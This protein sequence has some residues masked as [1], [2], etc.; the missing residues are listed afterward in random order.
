MGTK[1]LIT[2][3]NLLRRH[4]HTKDGSRNLRDTNVRKTKTKKE[5]IS[6]STEEGK[7]QI[8]TIDKGT[9][10]SEHK[11]AKGCVWIIVDVCVSV[12]GTEPGKLEAL[13]A[14]LPLLTSSL[15]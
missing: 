1:Y 15:E 6:S 11:E 4:L 10:H 7:R 12:L 3:T 14:P 9:G 2:R 13:P 5:W 8:L